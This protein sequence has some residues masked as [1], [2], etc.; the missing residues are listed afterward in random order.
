VTDREPYERLPG[1]TLAELDAA[2]VTDEAELTLRHEAHARACRRLARLVAN[3]D[4]PSARTTYAA[5]V[6]LGDRLGAVGQPEDEVAAQ[7]IGAISDYVA[8]LQWWHHGSERVI[9]MGAT[10]PE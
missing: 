4:M 7:V 5:L 8:A 9:D 1:M 2:L 10:P 3:L 6:D